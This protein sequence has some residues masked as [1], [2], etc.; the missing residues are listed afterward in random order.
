MGWGGGACLTQGTESI[1]FLFCP[2]LCLGEMGSGLVSL[3]LWSSKALG[4][5]PVSTQP[6]S[7]FSAACFLLKTLSQESRDPVFLGL[8]PRLSE[9]T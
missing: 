7:R 2:T 6:S 1:D 4:R 3:H 9:V 5:I 8:H